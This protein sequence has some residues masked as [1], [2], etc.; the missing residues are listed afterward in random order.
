MTMTGSGEPIEGEPVHATW[1]ERREPAVE[2][3]RHG[4]RTAGIIL[5]AIG[6]LLLL[7]QLVP[8]A[9][10]LLL[11][12]LGIGFYAAY[13]L[14]DRRRG[15]L[16]AGGVLG[17]LGLGIYLSGVLRGP[18]SAD[19]AAFFLAWAAGWASIYLVD[20]T[21]KW[22]LWP[23]GIFAAIGVVVTLSGLPGLA[24]VTGLIWPLILIGL[25]AWLLWRR[26][27]AV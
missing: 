25:G 27:R 6:V 16:I 5:I 13:F 26:Q 3:D 12:A 11:L 23:A 17:G 8:G 15:F 20:R 10:K 4:G 22:P 21:Q 2:R 19:G 24:S 14:A 9:D 18:G 1:T 7:T